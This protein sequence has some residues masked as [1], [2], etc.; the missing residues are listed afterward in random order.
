[1]VRITAAD[2]GAEPEDGGANRKK[3][4]EQSKEVGQ[5][6]G[7]HAQ[8]GKVERRRQDRFATKPTIW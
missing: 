1:M 7:A 2:K 6:Y 5:Q 3:A 8:K 4:R